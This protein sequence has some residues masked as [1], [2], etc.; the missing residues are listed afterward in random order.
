VIPI[1]RQID[2]ADRPTPP[3]RVE[4]ISTE[5]AMPL[6]RR[7]LYQRSEGADEDRW[8]LAFDTDANRL[9]VEH[10]KTRGDMRGSGYGIDTDEMDI[11][12]FLNQRGQGQ[13]ALI[14][15][16]GTLFEDRNEAPRP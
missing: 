1:T 4:V 2:S 15:L 9:F 7:P 8:R 13:Q 5:T 6:L 11:A 12:D 16:L 14:Q 10:E 3:G